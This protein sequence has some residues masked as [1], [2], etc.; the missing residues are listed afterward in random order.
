LPWSRSRIRSDTMVLSVSDER[1]SPRQ[2]TARRWEAGLGSRELTAPASGRG[3]SGTAGLSTTWRP[4]RWTRSVIA[5]RGWR[6]CRRVVEHGRATGRACNGGCLRRGRY[7]NA[8]AAS[9]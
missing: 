9:S 5:V 3:A 1:V 7:D 6:V 4:R 8:T 2:P